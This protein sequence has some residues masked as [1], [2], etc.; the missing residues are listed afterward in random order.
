MRWIINAFL[1]F[2]LPSL[3]S[4]SCDDL[5]RDQ[6]GT[7]QRIASSGE[8]RVGLIENPP[9][10]IRTG[11]EPGGVEVEIIKKFAQSMNARPVWNW[12]GEERL[13]PAL[14][15]NKMD[16]VAGG[17]VKSSPWK[18][19][20]GITSPYSQDQVIATPPG[21]NQLIKRLDEF[22]STNRPDIEVL[23][24]QQQNAE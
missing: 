19:R 18:D 17:I 7:V 11:N 10:V 1:V 13:M 16:L 5:P 12:G 14:E 8:M 3:M 4:F 2:A 20:V 21:E 22:L 15:H 23:L 6:S 9:F 24:A